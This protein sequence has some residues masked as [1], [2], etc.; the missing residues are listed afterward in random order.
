MKLT[1]RFSNIRTT[2]LVATVISALVITPQLAR[3]KDAMQQTM[4]HLAMTCHTAVMRQEATMDHQAMMMEH[5]G[6]TP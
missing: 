6:T 2:P 4:K 1:M 3:T 5:C